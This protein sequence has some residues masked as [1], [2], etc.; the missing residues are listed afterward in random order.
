[1]LK[2]T[3]SKMNIKQKILKFLIEN[4]EKTFSM[5][6]LSKILKI[7]YKLLYIN[8]QK[9]EKDKSIEVE[10]LKNQKRCSFK[11]NFNEDVFIVENERRNN[12]LKKKEF[13]AIYE[14]LKVL[15]KQFI[16]ILF[17]SHVKGTA[18][19]HSDIDLL[20]ISHEGDARKIQEKLEILPLNIHLTPITYESFIDMLKTKEQTVVSEA[21]KKKIIFIGIEDYYR[22]IQNAK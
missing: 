20:L 17:G 1:M 19:K 18:T 9:L 12:I 2:R 11:D 10:N 7:D 22:L 3:Y 14:K 5:R 13:K 21:L 15:N 16:L 4:K 6:A 8:L